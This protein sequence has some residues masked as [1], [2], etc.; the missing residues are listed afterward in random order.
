VLAGLLALSLAALPGLEAAGSS[1]PPV[2]QENQFTCTLVIGYSQVAQWYEADDVFESTVDGARWELKW[3]GGAGVDRWSDPDNRAWSAELVSPCVS[4]A[5]APDRIVLSVSGPYGD[6]E[7]AWVEGINGSVALI[8][9]RYP[10][11]RVIALIPVVG[12]PSH[13][14]CELEGR[15]VRASWQHE[16]IDNAIEQV[17]AADRTGTLVVGPSPE[18]RTCD[19]YRDALGHLT[20]E[21][22]AALGDMLGR[23]MR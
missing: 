6:D 12:G 5:D 4:N 9:Q 15:S 2:P 19:D 10:T 23:V 13:R 11:A 8:R 20:D 21:G 1:Q 16:H 3:A 7:D 14:T 17:V 22:A 18:V